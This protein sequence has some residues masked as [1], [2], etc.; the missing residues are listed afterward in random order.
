VTITSLGSDT[1]DVTL[2]IVGPWGFSIEG[3]SVAHF[4]NSTTRTIK[5]QPNEPGRVTC[6]LHLS[7]SSGSIDLML[8]GRAIDPAEGHATSIG[9]FRQPVPRLTQVPPL[10]PDMTPLV[11]QSYSIL[12]YLCSENLGDPRTLAW[13]YNSYDTMRAVLRYL[14]SMTDY[15]AVLFQQYLYEYNDAIGTYYGSPNMI[16]EAFRDRVR[17]FFPE[18]NKIPRLL[19][20]NCILD[21]VVTDIQDDSDANATYPIHPLPVKCITAKVLDRLKG[22]HLLSFDCN[23]QLSRTGGVGV[24]NIRKREK[25]L[26]TDTN[27]CIHFIYSP[28]WR[29]FRPW[30]FDVNDEAIGVDSAG[31]PTNCP[32]CYGQNALVVGQ[33]YVI[34]LQARLL[35]FIGANAYYDYW[36]EMS[37]DPQGGI[38][39]MV[40]GNVIDSSNYWGYGSSV[41][42]D[43]FKSDLQN[44]INSILQYP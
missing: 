13:S 19:N 30:G 41:P 26:G 4:A 9:C 14:Y 25:I 3:G 12:D 29:K 44:D 11:L 42:L 28:F 33:E 40:D 10:R 8:D 37:Y 15:D 7:D 1:I 16:F 35:D 31:N 27:Q 32:D 21:I 6:R 36:P 43:Q 2:Q 18:K 23:Q 17:T 34:V 38:F 24:R 22:Q 39:P 20:P 5:F